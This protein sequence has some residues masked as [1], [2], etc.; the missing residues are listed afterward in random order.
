MY[1]SNMVQES[2]KNSKE[3]QASAPVEPEASVPEQS[4]SAGAPRKRFFRGRFPSFSEQVF[5]ALFA[6]DF[7]SRLMAVLFLCSLVGVAYLGKL[8]FSRF[9]VRA[10]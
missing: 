8:G 3:A 9:L 2:P 7:F 6:R 5:G 4:D 1:P 10:D